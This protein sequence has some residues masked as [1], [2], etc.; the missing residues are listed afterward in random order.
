MIDALRF[1][2][3]TT[4]QEWYRLEDDDFHRASGKISTQIT[5]QCRFT[6]K[7]EEAGNFVEYLTYSKERKGGTLSLC[8]LDRKGHRGASSRQAQSARRGV[9][10]E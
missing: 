8:Q 6:L 2:L 10:W 1:A 5:I 7:P 9:F 4:D 3:G